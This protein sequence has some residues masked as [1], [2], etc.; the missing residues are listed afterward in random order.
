MRI[1]SV[2]PGLS[3]KANIKRFQKNLSVI[4]IVVRLSDH[5]LRS[6]RLTVGTRGLQ[7]EHRVRLFDGLLDR[8]Q[9]KDFEIV[10][11]FNSLNLKV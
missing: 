4:R 11:I 1:F 10:G 8:H 3:I 5:R 9:N 2:D 7:R 6:M